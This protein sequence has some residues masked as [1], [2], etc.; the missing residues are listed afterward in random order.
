LLQEKLWEE[1]TGKRE[2]A[3]LGMTQ[4][5]NFFQRRIK[6]R[7]PPRDTEIC[8]G[9][10]LKTQKLPFTN[11]S[12]LF[13]GRRLERN[14]KGEKNRATCLPAGKQYKGTGKVEV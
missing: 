11:S 6:L 2:A 4:H 7:E 14:K 1:K 10:P 13:L 5:G 8:H 3:A 9:V 12:L